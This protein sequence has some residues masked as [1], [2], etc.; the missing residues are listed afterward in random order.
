MPPWVSVSSHIVSSS[1]ESPAF[2]RFGRG[3][4]VGGHSLPNPQSCV[5]LPFQCLLERSGSL[6]SRHFVA[7][8]PSPSP[9]TPKMGWGRG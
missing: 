8:S 2:G 5:S 3:K 1:P 6:P 9:P 7:P 4:G